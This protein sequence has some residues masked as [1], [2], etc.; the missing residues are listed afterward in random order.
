MPYSNH[1]SLCP[2]RWTICAESYNSLLNNYEL[3]QEA[4]YTLIEEKD[5]PGIE[6]NGLHEQMNKFYFFFRLKLGY[7]IFSATETLSRIIQSSSCCLQDVLSSTK[8]LI[9]YF[10]RIRDDT[11]FKSFYTKILNESES[12]KDKPILTRHRRPPK[13]YQSSS[14]SVEFSSCEEFYR[15]QY[16][17]SLEIVVNMLQNRFTQKNFKLLCNVKKFILYAANNSLDDSNDY[18]QSVMDFLLW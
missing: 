12:L 13:S 14:D 10:E 18:F 11:N 15:Q 6:A 4:L 2:T 8:S 5:G 1:T 3:V 16:M 7:L 17:E 9:R